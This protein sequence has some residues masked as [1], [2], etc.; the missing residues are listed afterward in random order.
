MSRMAR[1]LGK[2]GNRTTAQLDRLIATLRYGTTNVVGLLVL[3]AALAGLFS[4]LMPTTFPHATTLQAMMFQI[5]ELGLLSLAMTVPLV[6]GGINLAIIA[7]ANLAGLLMAWILTAVMP[8]DASGATLALWLA[9]AL[10]AGLMICIVVGLVT[11]L[12]VAAVGVHPILVT[13]GTMTLLHGLGIYFTRGRTLSGFPDALIL[14]SNKTVLGIPISFLVFAVVALFIHVLL[15]RTELGVRIH[16]I[17]SNLE[18]TRYSGVD[19]HRVQVWVYIISSVLCWLAAI[20]MMARFN[21]AGADIAR[22]YLL[23]TILAAILGGVDPYG[24]F[25]RIVGLFIALWI[26]Q[27]IASGFNLMDISPHLALASWGLILLLVMAAKRI[28]A[29]F[30][31]APKAS[32][33]WSHAE[34]GSTP[35]RSPEESS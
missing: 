30:H 17:G 9:G 27:T 18:A 16:M 13:L 34:P 31:L 3:L 35:N 26:L 11:G 10:A 2:T 6:S 23:I 28:A 24:G 8:P 20:I 19:T 15:T 1:N 21:S 7:T 33:S 5:P 29:S 25:G 14:I 32:R 12:L 4:V 22:S